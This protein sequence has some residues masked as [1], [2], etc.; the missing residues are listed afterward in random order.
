MRFL[1]PQANP[2]EMTYNDV[3]L[4]PQYSDI[5]SRMQVDITPNG[6]L[7]TTIPLVIANMNAVAGKRMAETVTRRGGLVILPQDMN[8]ER[9]QRSVQYIKQCHPLYETP[10][11]LN[12]ED[13]IQ[14]ALNLIGKRAHGA[15]IV[16]DKEF[17][18]AGIFTEKEARNQDRFTSLR[19]VMRTDVITC[20]SSASAQDMFMML[21]K[22]RISL[23]P[24]IYPDGTLAG[25]MTKK[26]AVRSTIYKPAQNTDGHLLTAA[27]VGINKKLETVV[28]FLMTVG[29]DII[30]LDTAHGHQ[31]RMLDAIR[32]VRNLIGPDK[33]LVAGN[34]V[35]GEATRDFI[36]AG[37]SIVK[38][39]VG[40]GAMCTTRMMTGTGRPQFSAVLECSRVA[41]EMGGSVWADGG[42]KHPRDV[43]IA[44]AAG[45]S[46]I[47]VGSWFAGT[48]ESVGDLQH[49]EQGRPY[50]ENF[51][52][53]SRRAVV[54]R[55]D[56][57]AL[58]EQAKR[59]YFEEGI[60]TSRMYLQRG[61]ESAED[62]ID[63]ITAGVRSACA[64]AGARNLEEF[65][66]KAVV[67][68]QTAAGYTEGKPVA[69]SW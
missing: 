3:F 28:G 35:T 44:L 66:D 20:P 49:D 45:A 18:P 6:N 26:G 42:V 15:V 10:V 58:F 23:L 34:V 2:L 57:A 39:G 37:A 38:V 54:D 27:A 8:W 11:I 30:V 52:M 31:K 12:E 9:V 51:G 41:R 47:M 56:A 53:A 59:E 67:G 16:I 5:T 64:Y 22:N 55:N 7:G 68:I 65:H 14:T 13:T 48:H 21:D 62:I 4:V 43:A 24:I 60:S 40:P 25:V 19:R 46:H 32:I 63:S 29:V 50:K 17:R 33:A 61:A 1:N 69:E 36:E